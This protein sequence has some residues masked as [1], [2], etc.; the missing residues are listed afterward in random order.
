[1]D[2][3]TVCI[4]GMKTTAKVTCRIEKVII[5]TAWDTAYDPQFLAKYVPDGWKLRESIHQAIEKMKEGKKMPVGFTFSVFIFLSG[6]A[7]V[8][9]G[10]LVMLLWEAF[11]SLGLCFPYNLKYN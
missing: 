1:M 5:Y 10:W 9:S 8:M 3:R 7:L 6:V 2:S 4:P 11:W